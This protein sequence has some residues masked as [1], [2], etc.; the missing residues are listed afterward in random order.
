MITVAQ[1]LRGK[2]KGQADELAAWPFWYSPPKGILGYSS[3]M[4]VIFPKELRR[5]TP[6]LLYWN[7][8]AE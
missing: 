4:P 5:N 3:V 1:I 7:I 6:M 2:A 8:V